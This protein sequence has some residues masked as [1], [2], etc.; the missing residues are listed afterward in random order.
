MLYWHKIE[1]NQE[2]KHQAFEWKTQEFK[3]LKAVLCSPDTSLSLVFDKGRKV[4]LRNLDYR[5]TQG[6]APNKRAFIINKTLNKEI[7]LGVL[8]IFASE[9]T[10]VYFLLEK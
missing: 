4:V 6:V 1:L 5:K 7:I 2:A 10:S 8:S 3:C 9:N